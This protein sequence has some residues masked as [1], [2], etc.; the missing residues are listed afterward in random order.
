[1][2]Q[3]NHQ[4]QNNSRLTLNQNQNQ[5]EPKSCLPHLLDSMPG[6]FWH[7]GFYIIYIMLLLC[8]SFS[9]YVIAGGVVSNKQDK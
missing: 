8:K 7:F 1:M 5:A 3:T 4:P 6:A 9:K 2:F